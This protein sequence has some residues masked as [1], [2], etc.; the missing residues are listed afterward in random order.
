ML[1]LL[2]KHVLL[3]IKMISLMD[4]F[5]VNIL[6]HRNNPFPA[7]SFFFYY[8]FCLFHILHFILSF[9]SF[10][11]ISFIHIYI[12][13]YTLTYISLYTYFIFIIFIFHPLYYHYFYYYIII[14][15]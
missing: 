9:Y 13:T 11:Y 1:M 12:L 4:P 14:T 8:S 2:G 7:V 10:P 6:L 5:Q 3:L 15:F